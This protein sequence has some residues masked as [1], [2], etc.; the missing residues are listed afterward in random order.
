MLNIWVKKALLVFKQ[1]TDQIIPISD[2]NV[3]DFY[4][5]PA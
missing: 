2:V 5:V 3:S 1:I 4:V